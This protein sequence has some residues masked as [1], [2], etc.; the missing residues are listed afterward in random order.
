[1][2]EEQIQLYTKAVKEL[3]AGLL[4]ELALQKEAA[5]PIAP[6]SAI[7]RISRMDAI[8][9]K[10]MADRAVREIKQK[11]SRI[12]RIEQAIAD[13][14]PG[15]CIQCNNEIQFERLMFMPETR[16]CINCARKR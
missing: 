16:I 1:M 12:E 11:L 8:N 3:K 9:N 4:S 6:D 10:T 15:V 2:T 7:G 14:K 5:Q 13:G